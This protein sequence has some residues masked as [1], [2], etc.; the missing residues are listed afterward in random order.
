MDPF[1]LD[2]AAVP[3]LRFARFVSEPTTLEYEQQLR[4]AIE[5]VTPFYVDMRDTMALSL[6]WWRLLGRL[7]QRLHGRGELVIVGANQV[8]RGSAEL[9]Q[10]TRHLTFVDSLRA[11]HS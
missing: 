8:G 11:D 10:V 1:V 9:A 6:D 3:Q 5:V 4:D 2:I 7:G